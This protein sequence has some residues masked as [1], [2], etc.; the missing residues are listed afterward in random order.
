MKL[1]LAQ[2]AM[3]ENTDENLCEALRLIQMAEKQGADLILF[4]EIQL[5]PFFPQYAG[6]DAAAYVL[7]EDDARVQM[8]CAAC[9][10]AKLW[11]SPNFYL[12]YEGKRYDTSLLI[13]R[14]GRIVG[15]QKMV[16]IAQCPCFYEQDYN[17]HRMA[18]SIEYSID[19]AAKRQVWQRMILKIIRPM[20]IAM[21][22]WQNSKAVLLRSKAARRKAF[23]LFAIL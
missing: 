14:G 13:D 9:R 2:M 23:S 8:L 16:H 7:R 19:F 11:A 4:P 10:K 18:K 1:A 6:R 5:S 20:L 15:R 17:D 3:T 21:S 22:I 12:E